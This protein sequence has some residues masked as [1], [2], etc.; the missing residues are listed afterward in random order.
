[1]PDPETGETI[2]VSHMSPRSREDLA[3]RGKA[4]R[5]VAEYSMGLM[6]RTPD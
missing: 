3:R 6:G 5:L 4:L 1:M 2:P